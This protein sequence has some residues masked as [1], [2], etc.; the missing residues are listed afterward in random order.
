MSE[1]YAPIVSNS[2]KMDG[3]STSG[4]IIAVISLGVRLVENLKHIHDVWESIKDAP[5]SV[6]EVAEELHIL[7][8]ILASFANAE[9]VRRPNPNMKLVLESCM[10][11]SSIRP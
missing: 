4:G 9:L 3:L 10:L 8:T 2:D 5:A 11:I 1:L 6:R 7:S